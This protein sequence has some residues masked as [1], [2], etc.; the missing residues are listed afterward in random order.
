MALHP[1]ETEFGI[2]RF[3]AG[4]GIGGALP[5]LVALTSEY[6]PQKMRST[7]VTTMFSGYAV[8]GIMAALLGDGR[9]LALAGK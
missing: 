5:N 3:I 2:L 1:T 7:L 4:L 8:G 9:R 6:A